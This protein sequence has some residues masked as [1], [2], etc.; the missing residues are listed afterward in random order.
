M[1]VDDS[2]AV[3]RRKFSLI[4]S[5]HVMKYQGSFI[6]LVTVLSFFPHFAVAQEILEVNCGDP[7][8]SSGVGPYNIYD[9][10][11]G[12]E[13]GLVVTHHFT[14]Y[15]EEMAING[16]TLRRAVIQEE[17]VGGLALVAGNLD[18]TLRAIPNHA[19]AL[20]A[21]GIWQLRERERSMQDFLGAQANGGFKSAECY[22]KRAIMFTPEDAQVHLA[23]AIFRH[24]QGRLDLALEAYQETIR[25]VPNNT[26]AHYS[27]GLLYI[28]KEEFASARQ[29]A[30]RAYALGYPLAGLRN[31]LQR[32]GEWQDPPPAT[33]EAAP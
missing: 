24:K 12:K 13:I 29:H 32:R 17:R 27:L 18:Y 3:V 26:E 9:S 15:I 22:F 8:D 20:Y 19:R 1:A 11:L 6:V 28:E 2:G 14:P 5:G 33:G 4:V 7:Y 31:A 25:L 30:W 21:M 10:T 16:S 23:Y